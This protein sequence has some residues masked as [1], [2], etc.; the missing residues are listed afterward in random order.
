MPR[1]RDTIMRADFHRFSS[2][3]RHHDTAQMLTYVEENSRIGRAL[4]CPASTH[5]TLQDRSAA[6]RW[7]VKGTPATATASTVPLPAFSTPPDPHRLILTAAAFTAATYSSVS[8][9]RSRHPAQ[10]RRC[11]S[12]L[13]TS[14]PGSVHMA[15]RSSVSSAACCTEATVA[16]FPEE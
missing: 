4:E 10:I 14:G 3:H 12:R 13:S 9:S 2:I 6:A 1:Q 11:S 15:Y 5:R 16:Y 8:F 7:T